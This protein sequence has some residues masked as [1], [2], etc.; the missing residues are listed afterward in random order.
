[1]AA[2]PAFELAYHLSEWAGFDCEYQF[3]LTKSERRRFI[4]SYVKAFH[5]HPKEASA[6][7]NCKEGDV[8]RDVAGLETDVKYF[9]KQVDAFKGVPGM[10]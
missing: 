10:Y 5:E 4:E 1:M 8:A 2:P 6:D 9:E 7:V 3:I